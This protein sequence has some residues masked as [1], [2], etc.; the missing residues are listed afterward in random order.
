MTKRPVIGIPCTHSRDDWGTT[1]S[2][3]S[4]SY[5]KAIEQAGGVPLLLPLSES[6]AMLDQLY[7]LIDGQLLAGGVDINP[8]QY[9]HAHHPELGET[10]PLQDHSEV[11]LT[12]KAFQDGKPVLG[13]CRGHQMLNVALGGTLYQDIPS[14]IPGAL[15]HNFS[16]KAKDGSLLAHDIQIAEESWL[17]EVLEQTIIK[18]NTMHHQ[19]VR[20]VA[21]G[22]KVV[23]T[24]SDGVVEVIQSEG[25]HFAVGIQSHPEELWNTSEPRWQRLFA[26]YVAQVAK[27]E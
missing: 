22:L 7:G 27:A 12:R 3:N 1:A 15:D 17:A 10:S 20:D 13:I 5:L 16:A 8:D 24:S 19:A 6:Q 18:T 26:A 9:G 4:N 25:D 23:G 14:E 11:Y 2:G 21:P